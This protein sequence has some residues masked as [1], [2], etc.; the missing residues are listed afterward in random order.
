MRCAGRRAQCE[1]RGNLH[2]VSVLSISMRHDSEAHGCTAHRLLVRKMSSPLRRL[3][4]HLLYACRRRRRHRRRHKHRHIHRQETD[5]DI[6]TERQTWICSFIH[7][8]THT[9]NTQKTHTQNAHSV[10]PW[11]PLRTPIHRTRSRCH[12]SFQASRSSA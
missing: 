2:V 12:G 7:T 3:S 11:P 5:T 8:H 10:S 6:D 1:T 4:R 9:H